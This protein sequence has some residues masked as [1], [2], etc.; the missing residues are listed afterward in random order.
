MSGLEV[1]VRL[2]PGRVEG[3]CLEVRLRGELTSPNAPALQ[4]F[5]DGLGEHIPVLV[6][7]DLADVSLI[8]ASGVRVLIDT[9]R[10]FRNT[11][12]GIVVVRAGRAVAKVLELTAFADELVDG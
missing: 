7:L 1:H 11:G 6:Q 10:R 5:L 12:R 3:W 4:H 2:V 8:D 9:R